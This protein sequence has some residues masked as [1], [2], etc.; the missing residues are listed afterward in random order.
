MQSPGLHF[1][2]LHTFEGQ[3]RAGFEL[4][5]HML[6]GEHA[7]KLQFQVDAPELAVGQLQAFA[8]GM[9][10]RL[11]DL[12]LPARPLPER[13]F[14]FGL[15]AQ[16]ALAAQGQVQGDIGFVLLGYRAQAQRQWAA[17]QALGYLSLPGRGAWV[18]LQFALQLPRLP[19]RAQVLQVQ[20]QRAT[21]QAEP[22]H[23]PG[24]G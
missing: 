9:Q 17:V 3:L 16:R 6:F 22:W 1:C 13:Q 24:F 8:A 2:L 15:Q 21:E 19:A 4:Q 12:E 5:I 7:G 10:V 23:W 18:E 11:S 14:G 20:R